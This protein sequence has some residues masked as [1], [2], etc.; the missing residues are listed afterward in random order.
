MRASRLMRTAS[1]RPPRLCARTATGTAQTR[2]TPGTMLRSMTR[3]L[4]DESE[5]LL[6]LVAATSWAAAS[7][8][9]LRV[10]SLGLIAPKP[11][12]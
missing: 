1:I 8:G 12:E 3:T 11:G 10:S 6:S 9:A 2:P 7:S 4:S 5:M